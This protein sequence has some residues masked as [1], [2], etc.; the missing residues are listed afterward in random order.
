MPA[1]C[2]CATRSR[3]ALLHGPAELLPVSSSGARRARPVAA[4]AGPTRELDPELRKA[5]EV[6]LHAGTAVALLIGA[7]RAR[8]PSALRRL[9]APPGRLHRPGASLPPAVAGCALERPIERA[10]GHA[11]GDRRRAA[12]RRARRW[13][14]PTRAPAAAATARTPAPVDALVL[15]LA[16]ACA[17]CPGVSR[18]GAT[19]AAARLRG[20]RARA[21]PNALSRH[22]ALPVIV[23]AT[24]LKGARLARR[25]LPPELRAALAAGAGAS[26]ASTLAAAPPDRAR[27]SATAR[28]AYAAVPR[29]RWR[30][31]PW[32][33]SRRRV[34]ESAAMSDAYAAAG[35]DTGQA[36]A[37]R[38]GARRRAAARSS[39]GRA[40]AR[41]V[42]RAAGTTR[43]CC[44]RRRTSAS[45]SSTDGV[46]SK[47]VVAEQADRLDTVGIDCIAMNVNDLVCVG[48]EPIAM[49]DYL[50]VEQADPE[51][52]ARDRRRAEAR[53]RGR[54]HRDPRRRARACC[55]S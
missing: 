26:F 50:A 24:A 17:L 42:A 31:S 5:F 6:A 1:R 14:R 2:R 45:R 8:S 52:L 39:T 11:R 44:G 46:G 47:L 23:G 48:A 10:A 43:A 38:R 28:C 36:D 54:G 29:W 35:V 49:L 18:N 20:L 13:S 27:S 33:C 21:T 3:S 19:L 4:R 25:G 30:R 37:R 9:D 32:S 34:R 12:R 55:P 40:V 51:A 41:R 15:G 16:Q 7:A 22:V 53:R